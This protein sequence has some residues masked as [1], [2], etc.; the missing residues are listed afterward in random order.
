MKRILSLGAIAMLALFCRCNNASENSDYAAISDSASITGLTGDS[1]KLVKTAGI[2]FKVKNVEQGTRA[3]SALSRTFSGMLTYQSMEA[4]E[5]G[6]KELKLS[7]D[8]SLVITTVLTQAEITARIP[9]QH[10]E[11]FLYGVADLG[12]FT[13]STRL[14]VDDRSLQYLENALKQKSRAAVLLQPTVKNRTKSVAVQQT[15]ALK[16][17]AIEQEISNR[18]IDADVA[19][20]AVNLTL[21]QNPVVRKEVVVNTD[22]ESYQLPFG[23]RITNAVAAGWEFFLNVLIALAHLWA[24]GLS[25]LVMYIVYRYWRRRRAVGLRAMPQ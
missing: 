3:V 22:I 15:V 10:L 23:K 25:A 13:G 18:A 14:Q 21:F 5:Q 2:H 17:E 9:A 12:Y 4:T 1:V 24:F 19:Y 16:D 8:S 11:A 20:S 6:R 7:A